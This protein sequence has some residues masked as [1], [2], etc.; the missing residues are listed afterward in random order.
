MPVEFAAYDSQRTVGAL[1]AI[2]VHRRD[3]GSFR[4]NQRGRTG[5]GRLT[6]GLGCDRT[7]RRSERQHVQVKIVVKGVL[8]S[9][10]QK[11]FA[12]VELPP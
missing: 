1:H 2:G 3:G 5:D 8:D 11:L 9:P 6:G 10:L 7:W 12:Q 4:S